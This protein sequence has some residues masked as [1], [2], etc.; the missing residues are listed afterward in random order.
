MILF[1]RVGSTLRHVYNTQ[2][3]SCLLHL[4][5]QPLR[6]ISHPSYFNRLF[7]NAKKSDVL[8]IDRWM[9]KERNLLKGISACKTD[10]DREIARVTKEIQEMAKE[11]RQARSKQRSFR[12][13]MKEQ[14]ERCQKLHSVLDDLRRDRAKTKAQEDEIKRKKEQRERELTNMRLREQ[15]SRQMEAKSRLREYKR[16][17]AEVRAL[18][19]DQLRRELATLT[20][21]NREKG[22]QD[23]IRVNFR[24]VLGRK[25]EE[26][27][28][29]LRDEERMEAL[30]RE[31]RRACGGGRGATSA[32]LPAG[33]RP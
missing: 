25:R 18:Q 8:G 33:K 11:K 24:R 12:E 20:A 15:E 31:A 6:A 16:S 1:I 13:E 2:M 26:E 22:L 4:Q 29:A 5:D 32:S 3:Q 30:A 9:L 10:R 19:A 27:R 21:K 23:F 28:R 7:P 14:E 17:Q